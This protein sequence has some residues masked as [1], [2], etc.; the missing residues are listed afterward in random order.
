MNFEEQYEKIY[1][2]CYF[3]VH[4]RET[5]EDITQ[6]AFLRYLKA[7]ENKEKNITISYLYKIALN[8]CIDEYR[9]K[10][11]QALDYDVISE[12][13]L[14][15]DVV[16]R[17]F[18]REALLKLEEIDREILLLRYVNEVS[19]LEIARLYDISRFA[20]YRRILKAENKFKK[21]LE[22][23]NLR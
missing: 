6:E 1:R 4:N 20:V 11:E 15:E 18:V 5:A 14:E 13:N 10:Q 8:L 9:K 21:I 2:F 19:I 12:N 22:K 23:E 3:K 7:I 17:I 16:T